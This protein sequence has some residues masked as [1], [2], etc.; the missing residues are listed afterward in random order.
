MTTTLTPPRVTEDSTMLIPKTLKN[1]R[2]SAYMPRTFI[3]T[4]E[5]IADTGAGAEECA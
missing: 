1:I 4:P 3:S 2:E 5:S